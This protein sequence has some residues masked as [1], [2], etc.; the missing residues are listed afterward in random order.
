MNNISSKDIIKML[1]LLEL[2]IDEPYNTEDVISNFRKLSKIYHPDVSNERYKD[3]TKFKDLLEAKEFLINNEY[4]VNELIK[5]G[6]V[7]SK[8]KAN[9]GYMSKRQ[10]EE[11]Q[12]KR[13]NDIIYND[14][15]N[16]ANNLVIND[17]K[18][19]LTANRLLDKIKS[20]HPYNNTQSLIDMLL[21][22]IKD[23]NDKRKKEEEI[24]RE[25]EKI[26]KLE[27]LYLIAFGLL[28]VEI[29]KENKNKFKSSI[30]L[31]K[32]LDYKDSREIYYKLKKKYD[33]YLEQEKIL[34]LVFRKKLIK[35]SSIVVGIIS[36]LTITIVL[37]INLVI[38][39][40]IEYDKKLDEYNNAIQAID[41]GNYSQAEYILKD[42]DFKDSEKIYFLLK[43]RKEFEKGD[44]EAGINYAYNSGCVTTIN[45][46]SVGGE[47]NKENEIIKLASYVN[48]ETS[49]HGYEFSNWTIKEYK[50]DYLKHSIELNLIAVYNE[51]IYSI[52]YDLNGGY[53]DNKMDTFTIETNIVL[54]APKK[55]GYNF[56]GWYDTLTNKITKDYA[57][58]NCSNDIYLEAK[59][60]IVDYVIDYNYSC[61][62]FENE[63]E[64]I[65][66]YNV[67]NE[68]DFTSFIPQKRG[69]TFDGWFTDKNFANK[70]ETTSLKCEN[71]SLYAKFS[72]IECILTFETGSNYVKSG[73]SD[74]SN[75]IVKIDLFY[76]YDDI[77]KTI[78]FNY[79]DEASILKTLYDFTPVH[80]SGKLFCGWYYD[81]DFNR[82][83]SQNDEISGN[84]KFYA[85]WINK[86]DYSR[87]VYV[88]DYLNSTGNEWV[89]VDGFGNNVI[90]FICDVSEE[91][92]L[93]CTGN[94]GYNSSCW[95]KLKNIKNMTSNQIVEYNKYIDNYWNRSYS[96]YTYFNIGVNRYDI[97]EI[98]I[99][100]NPERP[101]TDLGWSVGMMNF[102]GNDSE[103]HIIK[104]VKDNH[105]NNCYHSKSI[106]VKYDD[107]VSFPNVYTDAFCINEV[108]N[109]K[110]V[111][112]Y[113][114]KVLSNHFIW[115]YLEDITIVYKKID[116]NT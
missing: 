2:S 70:I 65:Y 49:K 68:V 22:K 48:N 16:K 107:M 27:E 96:K 40:K 74:N 30:D 18:D 115:N 34:I 73:S 60:E 114:N 51:I 106:V 78:Y 116:E 9:N 10:S 69:Y 67:E 59:W 92:V 25:Q 55:N 56:I 8:S 104:D 3:G 13:E 110:Y 53:L 54:D 84:Q 77:V 64:L 32:D 72:P 87:I 37:L 81:S 7:F 83:L 43:S 88:S 91:L 95:W 94:A 75:S 12:K 29:N 80:P 66:S 11:E 61:D 28:N 31:M 45:Y 71:L 46:D 85:K 50:I 113:D 19:V 111:W 76:N 47:C 62:T 23:Y 15:Y 103:K 26:K 101:G 100:T 17:D 33:D 90:Y 38:V 42:M 98:N 58:N 105:E 112:T 79:A 99:E 44:Y 63:D 20:I 6:F 108:D 39:P 14:C 5:N 89:Y 102:T 52:S 86:N 1:V 4:Y 93:R 24:R 109:D 35:V 82:V 21:K 57:I 36:L 41:N 97:I